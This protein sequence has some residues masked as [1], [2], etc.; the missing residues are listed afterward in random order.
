M[1][2]GNF[3]MAVGCVIWVFPSFCIGTRVIIIAMWHCN[4]MITYRWTLPCIIGFCH[5]LHQSWCMILFLFKKNPKNN[6]PKKR[7]KPPTNNPNPEK[8]NQT[9]T[10][11]LLAIVILIFWTF[12]LRHWVLYCCSH[13]FNWSQ[14]VL[15]FELVVFHETWKISLQRSLMWHWKLAYALN[16]NFSVF[17][18]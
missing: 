7:K 1:Q 17:C 9:P 5:S 13:G 12:F 14:W 16:F 15:Y 11:S 18:L 3:R 10:F 4:Y 8:P 2:L 6:Q